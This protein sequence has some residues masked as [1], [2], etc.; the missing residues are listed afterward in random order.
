MEKLASFVFAE[1]SKHNLVCNVHFV[2]THESTASESKMENMKTEIKKLIAQKRVP[3]EVKMDCC[4]I[5]LISPDKRPEAPIGFMQTMVPAEAVPE[6]SQT[7]S[8]DLEQQYTAGFFVSFDP[9]KPSILKEIKDRI[10][11]KIEDKRAQLKPLKDDCDVFLFID[12]DISW[13]QLMECKDEVGREIGQNFL[14]S[15]DDLFSLIVLTNRPRGEEK[16]FSINRAAYGKKSISDEWLKNF[17][18]GFMEPTVNHNFFLKTTERNDPCP[19]GVG[20]KF[21]NCHGYYLV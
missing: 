7:G 11:N 12:M 4:N 13:R 18:E 20:F 10:Y 21:K 19:C 14:S 16:L 6:I 1:T 17:W 9:I 3:N 5:S 8:T 15:D 2:A